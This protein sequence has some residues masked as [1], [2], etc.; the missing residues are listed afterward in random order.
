MAVAHKETLQNLGLTP[1]KR[2][3]KKLYVIEKSFA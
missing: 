3:N 2:K 1:G